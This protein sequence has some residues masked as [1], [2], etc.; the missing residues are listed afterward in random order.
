M[1]GDAI[2]VAHGIAMGPS[3]NEIWKENQREPREPRATRPTF[4]TWRGQ[5]HHFMQIKPENAW[6]PL[7]FA[8]AAAAD[9]DDVLDVV[10]AR[11][12]ADRKHQPRFACFRSL[13]PFFSFP[14]LSLFFFLNSFPSLFF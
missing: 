6:F 8:A 10:Q 14:S 13:P 2:I 1:I 3:R 7:V 9:D 11:T 12:D 5:S 4:Q